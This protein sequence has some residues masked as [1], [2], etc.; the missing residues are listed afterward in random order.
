MTL[1]ILIVQAKMP[2]H[3]E[4]TGYTLVCSAVKGQTT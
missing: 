2:E 4:A 3:V 1:L